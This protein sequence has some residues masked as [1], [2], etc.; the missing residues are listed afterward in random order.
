MTLRPQ[1]S[2]TRRLNHLPQEFLWG[3]ASS[4]HQTEGRNTNSNWWHLEQAPGSPLTEPSGDAIDSYHR[5]PE[6]MRL[7]AEAGLT[8]YRFSIE[9]ARIEPRPGEVDVAELE[10][11]QRMI[12]TCLGL[13]LTPVVTLHHFTSPMWFTERNG[14]RADDAV[15]LFSRYVETAST[16][17]GD[18]GWVCTINEPNMIALAANMFS[19]SDG[20]T[21]TTPPTATSATDRRSVSA[22]ALPKPA[23]DIATAVT[24]AHRSAVEI[25]R[26]R[27]DALI[28]WT[29][30]NQA[31]EAV[32]GGEQ[33]LDELRWAWEDRFLEVAR[34]DDFVGVQS[35]TTRRV[36][37]D[38]LLPYPSGPNATQTGW[39]NRPD[40]LETAIRHTWE[41]TE[42]TPILVTENGIATTDD[43]VRVAYIAAALEGANRAVADGIDLRGYVYWSALDNYEWGDWD[44]NFGL[45][46]VDRTTFT[47]TPRP[48]L[49][50][51]G[52]LAQA[53]IARNDLAPTGADQE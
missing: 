30:S 17:L 10:H 44:A 48:S 42:Q 34:D 18:V 9:W 29:V 37:P 24:S 26:R 36:G 4:A 35:Y 3:A 40:A 19:E 12:D 16:I 23:D 1:P 14:W 33:V 11:Y 39:P 32:D 13:G 46:E 50:W 38:G 22:F 2:L 21:P 15:A 45:I 51:L 49:A 6:D 5:Y 47:R 20:S 41:V 8:A 43:D 25:L 7:L 27:T 53:N 28:G 52:E 31:F